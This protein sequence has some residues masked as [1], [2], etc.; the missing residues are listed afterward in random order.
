[1]LQSN[2][3]VVVAVLPYINFSWQIHTDGRFEY[4]IDGA[5][6]R[7]NWMKFINCA[8]HSAEQNLALVQ[9]DSLLYYQATRAITEG[10]ELRVWYG[11]QY[12]LLM[13]IPLSIKNESSGEL[14]AVVDAVTTSTQFYY[15]HSLVH[16]QSKALSPS[17]VSSQA[18]SVIAFRC[19]Q[20]ETNQRRRRR[21]GERQKIYVYINKQQLYTSIKIFCTFL[22]RRC[23]TTTLETS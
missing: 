12:R 9:Q 20:D 4:Y 6:N 17:T 3:Y 2:L 14:K 5:T 19:R 18:F 22:C 1:M 16:F 21:Q 15:R 10:Q 23:T 13:G 7:T 8:R 11:D